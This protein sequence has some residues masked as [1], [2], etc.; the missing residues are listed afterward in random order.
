ME[1]PANP[2]KRSSLSERATDHP[3]AATGLPASP[4]Q[5]ASAHSAS[6]PMG[7]W[8]KRRWYDKNPQ[9]SKAIRCLLALPVL[10]QDLVCQTLLSLAA[11]LP[12]STLDPL[13]SVGTENVLALYK[14]RQKRRDYDQ[15]ELTHDTLSQL[16]VLPET[17]RNA[18]MVHINQLTDAFRE[19]LTLCKQYQTKPNLVDVRKLL[20]QYQA[21]GPEGCTSILATIHEEWEAMAQLKNT[22][23]AFMH[24]PVIQ[25][26]KPPKPGGGKPLP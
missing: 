18:M 7:E 13:K 21:S 2:P 3:A 24:T 16:S 14:A 1:P 25:V 12:H 8:R 11:Q 26:S 4:K 20:N 9:A 17:K 5:D 23:L 15:R 6:A 19:Y 22:N 10:F